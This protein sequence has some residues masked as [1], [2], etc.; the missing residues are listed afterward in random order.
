MADEL[1]LAV[2]LQFYY[3]YETKQ[4]ELNQDPYGDPDLVPMNNVE[5]NEAAHQLTFEAE[6][7][8]KPQ[9]FEITASFEPEKIML[10]LFS[11]LN[12]QEKLV[13][14][15]D[16]DDMQLIFEKGKLNSIRIFKHTKEFEILDSLNIKSDNGNFSLIK[17]KPWRKFDLKAIGVDNG[18][19][20]SES[21]EEQFSF[22]LDVQPIILDTVKKLVES[23]R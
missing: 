12:N 10:D 19:I 9:Q 22:H 3:N 16:V 15:E 8:G 11:Q 4:W 17:Q 18:N 7:Q 5:L 1:V 21:A 23:A 20:V 14:G 13:T 6:Y 2:G